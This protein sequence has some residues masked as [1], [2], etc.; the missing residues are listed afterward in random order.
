[1]KAKNVL[2]FGQHS[3]KRALTRYSLFTKRSKKCENIPMASLTWVCFVPAKGLIRGFS[4]NSK[5]FSAN[6]KNF[7]HQMC[8]PAKYNEK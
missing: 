8:A 4:A 2:P 5:L 1:M 7:I 6:S 3:Y